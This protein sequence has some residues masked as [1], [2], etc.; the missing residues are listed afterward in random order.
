MKSGFIALVLGAVMAAPG[1]AQPSD[2]ALAPV[3]NALEDPCDFA[4]FAETYPDSAFA[5][6][7]SRR[8]EACE[9]EA[10]NTPSNS[11]QPLPVWASMAERE[12]NTYDLREDVRAV[13]ALTDIDTLLAAADEGDT[14]AAFLAA[15]A[16]WYGFGTFRNR[17]RAAQYYELACDG[18]HMRS[19]AQL[20]L[21]YTREG[22]FERNDSEAYRYLNQACE[23]GD[24]TGCSFLGYLYAVGRNVEEDDA[25]AAQLYARACDAGN[26]SGCGQ[27]GF[28]YGNGHGVELDGAR[29]YTLL[30]EGCDGGYGVACSNLGSGYR[31]ARYGVANADLPR[32]LDFYMRGCDL[33]NGNACQFA[34]LIHWGR[35]GG[36][37]DAASAITFFERSCGFNY[38]NGCDW[39]RSARRLLTLPS[40]SFTQNTFYQADYDALNTLCTSLEETP[41]ECQ[42]LASRT[43][44]GSIGRIEQ[45]TVD[46][47]ERACRR[48]EILACATLS[49][50]FAFGG[51]GLEPDYERAETLGRRACEA[52]E[53]LGCAN[54]VIAILAQRTDTASLE[55]ARRLGHR[56][57]LANLTRACT[58]YAY[59]Y[60]IED[61]PNAELE[62]E[63]LLPRHCSET[64]FGQE[65]CWRLAQI[66]IT[67]RGVD[68]DMERAR[69]LAT[70][71]CSDNDG[72]P[73]ACEWLEENG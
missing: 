44:P 72:L 27:L 62:I 6:M 38:E 67:E 35:Y 10:P 1:F 21:F 55:D 16:M 69:E 18:G 68:M 3:Y 65:A 42:A 57:C 17:S 50:W 56:G 47:M 52:E 14:T 49:K 70:T 54:A 8:G 11:A 9:S 7:A 25:Q 59:T 71:A 63:R 34:G 73:I 40:G 20:G 2:E 4:V 26:A 53:F 37:R 29:A 43:R 22:V 48:G 51:A 45:I 36:E 13:M 39:I 33:G 28:M 15:K 31:Q 66:Y 30:L 41:A 32:A 60:D 19:C 46:G 5:P 24:S 58:L 12:W 64:T 23:A 61:T